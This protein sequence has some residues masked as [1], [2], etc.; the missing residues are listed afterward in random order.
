MS[1]N[2][3]NSK[4][5]RRKV[6]SSL[7]YLTLSKNTTRDLGSL[8]HNLMTT[9][10]RINRFPAIRIIQHQTRRKRRTKK[11]RRQRIVLNTLNHQNHRVTRTKRRR[12]R[13]RQRK[14]KAA[15]R[16]NARKPMRALT[17][18]SLNDPS[19]IRKILNRNLKILTGKSCRN[20]VHRSNKSCV[21]FRQKHIYNNFT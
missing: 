1:G 3:G 13:R 16:R 7:Q 18:W 10:S 15:N 5:H 14:K 9:T 20:K 17:R 12:R 6:T 4:R 8:G 11:I 21:Q 2:Q 19:I